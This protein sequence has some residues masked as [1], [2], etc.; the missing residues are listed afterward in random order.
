MVVPVH[1]VAGVK[2]KLV[3]AMAL[4]KAV[5]STADGAAGL[6][7]EHDKQL[8]IAESAESF[9]ENIVRLLNDKTARQRLGADARK[10]VAD[11]LS[12]EVT[13]RQVQKILDYIKQL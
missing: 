4:G 11:K 9:A 8:L 7:V 10:F 12:P 1:G 6:D 13:E 2:I 3:E 5:V